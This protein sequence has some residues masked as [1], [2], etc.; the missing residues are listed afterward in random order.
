MEISNIN[1]RYR[2]IDKQ[3]GQDQGV[4]FSVKL[5]AYSRR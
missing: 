4:D 3:T 5:N 2:G 1:I